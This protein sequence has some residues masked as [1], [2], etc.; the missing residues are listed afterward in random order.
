MTFIQQ[1]EID[2]RALFKE[3]DED[4][5]VDWV[6]ERILESYRN[7]QASRRTPVDTRKPQANPPRRSAS[8]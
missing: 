2:F 6:K 4:M 8:R 7:G 3:N 1:C 5:L